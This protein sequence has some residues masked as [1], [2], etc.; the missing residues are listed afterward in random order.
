MKIS[1]SG[2]GGLIGRRLTEWWSP[3]HTLRPVR[4]E[5]L[6]GSNSALS[7]ELADSDVLIHLSGAPLLKRWTPAY[8]EIIRSSR[9]DTS[10]RLAEAVSGKTCRVHTIL[11]ASAVGIYDDHQI[12]TEQNCSLAEDFTAEICKAWE[13]AG[14]AFPAKCRL[15]R[16]RLGIVLDPAGGALRRMLPAFRAGFGASIGSGRQMM[17]WIHHHDL[18]RAFS[19]ALEEDISGTFNL[20]SP[21]P[22]SNLEFSKTLGKV[23]KRPCRLR[24]PEALLKLVYGEAAGILSSGQEVIPERL[25]R[26]GFRFD[27]PEAGPALKQLLKI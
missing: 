17:S 6:Y 3:Q 19:Y 20:C 11:L 22:V 5:M 27:F 10:L 12:Q 4:R 8:R 13:K 14:E 23:L 24:I 18:C 7:A 9:V 15:V 26:A 1:I 25:I 21:K 16:F 2:S